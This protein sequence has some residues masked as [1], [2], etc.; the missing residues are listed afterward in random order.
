MTAGLSAQL[1]ELLTPGRIAIV[2][3]F[4]IVGSFT[5]DYTWQPRYPGSLPRVGFGGGVI[6]NIRN[7][8][9]YLTHFNSW[10]EEGYAKYTK[11]DRAYVIPSAPSRPQEIVIPQSQA[12]WLLEFP[13]RLVSAKA[14]HA[15]VLYND[16]QL[17][18]IDDHLSITSVHRHLPRNLVGLLP[19]IQDEVHESIDAALGLDTENWKTVN[20]WEAWLAIVPRVTNR[21]VVGEEYCKNKA[22]LDLQVKFADTLVTNSFILNMFP[23]VVLRLVAPLVVISNWRIWRKSFGIIGPLIEQRLR[24]MERKAAGDEE[25]EAWEPEECL[26]TWMIRQAQADGCADKV[27][28]SLL[29]KSILPVEFAAIH[30]TVIT[31]H[32]LLLDLLAADPEL[33]CL[34]VIRSEADRVFAEQPAGYWTKDGL[35]RLH[36]TDSCIR[37]SMR[38]SHFAKA[39]THRKV[40]AKEGITN[41]KEGWHIPYGSFLML[42]LAGTHHDA[43]IYP[44]PNKYDPWRFSR[45]KEEF[46]ARPEEEKSIEEAL[47]IKR[48]GMSTTSDTFLP[49]SHGRHACPGRFFVAHELKMILTYLVRNYE[50]KPI[51]ER[52]KPMWIGQTVIPPVQ[53]TM[54]IRRRK[55]V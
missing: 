46:D 52:P 8:A 15:D 34:N 37:E 54:E 45:V 39:L 17:L 10:V 14:A 50:I 7:W 22:F 11:H 18:G 33:G 1:F 2:V 32:N 42:D 13:D 53:A 12:A 6:G 35:S 48:L 41:T 21:M 29:S 25:Y 3:F 49:F 27:D 44:E 31:G 20:I 30:T 23:K 38:V 16:Y 19:G 24:D 43:D 47:K 36:R 51:K 40:V 9:T 55:A 28:A 5:V 26:L 4:L